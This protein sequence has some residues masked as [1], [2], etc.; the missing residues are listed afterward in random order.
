MKRF[1]VKI[2]IAAAVLLL[3]GWLVFT[4]LLPQYYLPVLPWMLLFFM[5]VTVLVHAWQ[6]NLAKKDFA[7]FSRYSMLISFL[8]LVVYSAFAITYIAVQSENL[9]AF[10]I[11]LMLAY[12]TFTSIEIIDLMRVTKRNH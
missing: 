7:K 4:F 1:I 9:P 12:A 2:L 11:C 6:L 8:K 5:V 10:V 3:A